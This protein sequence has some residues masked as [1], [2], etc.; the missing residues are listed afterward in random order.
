MQ[1]RQCKEAHKG[2]G[3][4]MNGRAAERGKNV[5][6]KKYRMKSKRKY[7]VTV[8]V[9]VDKALFSLSHNLNHTS[10]THLQVRGI[11]SKSIS[12]I[13]IF[14]PQSFALL[15]F[16]CCVFLSLSVCLLSRSPNTHTLSFSTFLYFYVS[17]SF[18]LWHYHCWVQSKKMIRLAPMQLSS[19]S[20]LAP[21]RAQAGSQ[22]RQI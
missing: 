21:N 16:C 12:F 7:E 8:V 2:R 10:H 22:Q 4:T 5:E 1:A 11:Y 15:S 9:L 18:V 6:K 19:P 13:F 3:T 17:P 20:S 14:P